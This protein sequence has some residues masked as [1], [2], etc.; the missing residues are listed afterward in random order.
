MHAEMDDPDGTEIYGIAAFPYEGQ[1]GGLPQI[2]RSLPHLGYID[3]AV[4][5]SRDGKKWQ[6]EKELVLSRGDVGE[7]DR[8][9][10]CASTRPV[11]VGGELWVYYS[12]RLYR[13]KE[14]KGSGLKDTGPFLVGIGL[15]TLRLDGFCSMQAGFDGGEI[16]TKPVILPEGSLFINAKSDWGEVVVEVLETDGGIIEGMRSIPVSADG[17]RLEVQWPDGSSF[18]GIA[19]RPVRLKFSIRNALL[20]SWRVE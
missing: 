4:A 1:W 16:I 17:V 13:H 5:H 14:Y 2:H 9:N 19:G 6:R 10:Q 7:W 8:F 11:R 20:Y 12:G 15:A 18:E 3:V